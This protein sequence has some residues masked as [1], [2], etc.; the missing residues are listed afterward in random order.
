MKKRDKVLIK[1][2]VYLLDTIEKLKDR[3]FNTVPGG[4]ARIYYEAKIE[5]YAEI[6][7]HIYGLI[8][9]KQ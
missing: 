2:R 3:L 6:A 5:A 4:Q 9:D 8:K 1:I 7:E